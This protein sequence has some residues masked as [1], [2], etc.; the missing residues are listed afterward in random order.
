MSRDF[1]FDNLTESLR[2]LASA[3]LDS[4]KLYAVES[5]ALL[6]GEMVTALLL[7]LLLA[8]AAMFFLLAL[9]V[10]L[11]AVVG[12]LYA[13]LIVGGLLLLVAGF[14]VLRGRRLFADMF[15]ARFCKL[16]FSS[17]DNNIP[18]DDG[19]EKE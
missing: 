10:A 5:L 11:S 14:V 16:F 2:E 6:S 8:G 1:D 17:Y 3:K 9:L 19:D 13:C 18:S 7:V 15:V 12:L 4:V